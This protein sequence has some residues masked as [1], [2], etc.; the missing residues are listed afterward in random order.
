LMRSAE[1]WKT[2]FMECREAISDRAWL[3]TSTS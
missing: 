3:S 2:A 1:D